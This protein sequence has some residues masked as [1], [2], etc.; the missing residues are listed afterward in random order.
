MT[1]PTTSELRARANTSLAQAPNHHRLV[2]ISAGVSALAGLAVS[3]IN[4]LLQQSIGA[5][6]GLGGLGLRS[7]LTTVQSMLA[8]AMTVLL[9][10]WSLGYTAV[11]LK[12]SRGEHAEGRDLLDGFRIF[13]PALRLFFLQELLYIAL[14][15]VCVHLGSMLLS[16]TPL[17]MDFYELLLPVMLEGGDPASIDPDVLLQAMTPIFIGCLVIFVA[18]AIPVSYRLRMAQYFLLTDPKAGARRALISSFRMTK[19]N[20]MALFRLD[21]SFWWFYVL[22]VLLAVICYGDVLLPL[23]GIEMDATVAYFLFYAVSLAL[24]LVLYR[25]AKNRISVTYAHAYLSL[26]ST[27]GMN[28]E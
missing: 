24:Q 5:T 11:T 22:D 15:L 18:V 23:L 27:G 26:T 20:A 12:L 6:G 2:L 17:A 8:L 28:N 25:Y 19:G 1:L 3:A 14:A 4:L 10:F 7:V 9:P 13:L 16:F 21:L